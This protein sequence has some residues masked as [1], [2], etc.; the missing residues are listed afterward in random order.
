[1]PITASFHA[2]RKNRVA[3]ARSFSV[4]GKYTPLLVSAATGILAALTVAVAVWQTVE[5]GTFPLWTAILA[6]VLVFFPILAYV[7]LPRCNARA[8]SGVD[9]A[10]F[11]YT[12]DKDGMTV[13]ANGDEITLPL[14]AVERLVLAR[15]H[16]RLYT[17]LSVGF[18]VDLSTLSAPLSE[19]LPLFAKDCTR[20]T[21]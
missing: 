17:G 8:L 3:L 18:A 15:E 4:N 16:L 14:A 21:K 1:M 20:A 5:T 6:P 11:S 9:G 13:A 19:L 12:F 7:I 2:T 10:R